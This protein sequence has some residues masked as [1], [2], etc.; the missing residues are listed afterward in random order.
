MIC[1]LGG[2]VVGLT[3]ALELQ[4]AG[5]K[6]TLIADKFGRETTSDGAAGLF[7]PGNTFSAANPKLTKE[8]IETSYYHYTRL[9]DAGCGI[10]EISGYMFSNL[11]TSIVK[12]DLLEGLLPE[13]REV[14]EEELKICPG[15]WKYGS[16][17][18]TL[19][20]E[21]RL[22]LPWLTKRFEENGGHI[23]KKFVKSFDELQGYEVVVNC[24][25][26]GAKVLCNDRNMVALSGQ[27]FKVEAPWLDNFFYAEY[28]TYIIPGI[29]HVTLGGTRKYDSWS[30]DVCKYTSMEIW[31]KCTTLVPR[32]KESKVLYEW[33]GL[34]PHREGGVRVEK[35][36]LENG[37]K[38][39]HN[40]GHGGYGVT[41]APG[42]SKY[43]VK[44]VHEFLSSSI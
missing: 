3:T 27:V 11:D 36:I 18:K 28:D 13:Y 25:G 32:L 19:V 26:L 10:R 21:C 9:L 17:Y 44:L 8:W 1:V 29:S 22:Y 20:I 14:T 43:A 7:R 24:T 31:E 37:I 23:I 12:N 2:G 35:E 34:R 33:V 16:Y 40:Y 6:V 4:Q 15:D 42:S 5:L 41:S 38:V 39:V 30:R